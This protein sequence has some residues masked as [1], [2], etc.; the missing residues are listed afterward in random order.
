MMIATPPRNPLMIGV[1]RNAAT[2]PIRSRP[3]RAT[4]TPTITA[5]IPTNTT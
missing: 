4:N 1:D 3:A 5:T 2:H